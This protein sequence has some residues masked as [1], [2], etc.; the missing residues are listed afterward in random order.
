MAKLRIV[1]FVVGHFPKVA[2]R[3]H[4][5]FG[6]GRETVLA[7]I[8]KAVVDFR[9]DEFHLA[10]GVVAFGVEHPPFGHF[11]GGDAEQSGVVDHQ[12]VEGFEQVVAPRG[13]EL[14]FGFGEVVE[15]EQGHVPIDEEASGGEFAEVGVGTEIGCRLRVDEPFDHFGEE[16]TTARMV[17]VHVDRIEELGGHA[18]WRQFGVFEEGIEQFDFVIAA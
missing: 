18:L 11:G 1:G 6:I 15:G 17:G 8:L 12:F 13:E 14:F 16:A 5:G 7:D 3:L 10:Q 4:D 2:H 9:Q